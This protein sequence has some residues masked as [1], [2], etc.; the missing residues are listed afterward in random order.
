MKLNITKEAQ[1]GLA[2]DYGITGPEEVN[3]LIGFLVGEVK[4]ERQAQLARWYITE[5]EPAGP[6][7]Q[8]ANIWL[9][10]N[11]DRLPMKFNRI[12]DLGSCQVVIWPDAIEIVSNTL[13]D[14][15]EV[16]P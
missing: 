7:P 15:D 8:L 4:A 13:P 14:S 1:E 5:G 16:E 10:Q 12:L 6:D 11:K 2:R 3:P 9:E